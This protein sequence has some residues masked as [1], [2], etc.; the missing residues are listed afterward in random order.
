MAG[1]ERAVLVALRNDHQGAVD[2]I[3]LV[4]EYGDV[5]RPRFG[6]AV[7]ACP[8]AVI[9]VPLP[10][11]ALEGRLG[12]DLELVNVDALAE[13]L[14]QRL[15]EPRM[16]AEDAKRFIVGVGGKGGARRAGL[17]APHFLAVAAINLLGFGAQDGNF[18]LAEATRKEEIPVLVEILELLRGKLHGVLS[19]RP[20]SRDLDPILPRRARK[21]TG[22]RKTRQRCGAA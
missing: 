12:V 5:H 8:G 7:V 9:L 10:D 13:I 21:A 11:I 3:H 19:R 15:D 2:G 22:N 4:E 6:H 1:L 20:V 14:L 18:V 16:M 17:L